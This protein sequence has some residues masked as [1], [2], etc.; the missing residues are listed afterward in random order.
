MMKVLFGFLMCLVLTIAQTFA[1]SGGPWSGPGHVT[2]TGT[3][4]GVLVP[5]P[6]VNPAPPPPTLPADNSLALFTLTVT[7]K[8]LAT[9][10]SAVFRNGIFYPGTIEGSADPNSVQL[11]AEWQATLSQNSPNLHTTP[12]IKV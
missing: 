8:G 6:P 11:S 3:Y 9:G 12:D 10:V 5:I 1:I 2:V 7:H 4:A